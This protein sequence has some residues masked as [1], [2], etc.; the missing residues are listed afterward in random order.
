MSS[1]ALSFDCG[2]I[3]ELASQRQRPDVAC[4]AMAS[5]CKADDVEAGGTINILA[6]GTVIA[7]F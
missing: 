6:I 4:K 3:H 5:D 1:V 7:W 2:L